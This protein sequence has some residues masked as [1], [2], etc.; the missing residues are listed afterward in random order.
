[1]AT[2]VARGAFPPSLKR[3]GLPH[4]QVFPVIFRPTPDHW[5]EARNLTFIFCWGWAVLGGLGLA[6]RAMSPEANYRINFFWGY[7]VT[8]LGMFGFFWVLWEFENLIAGFLFFV[9]LVSGL[10]YVLQH[11]NPRGIHLKTRFAPFWA[12]IYTL[13]MLTIIP[14]TAAQVFGYLLAFMSIASRRGFYPDANGIYY[15]RQRYR[16]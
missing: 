3:R 6:Y 4:Y 9:A 8:L 14:Y 5:I 16:I 13:A 7:F 12:S 10:Y 15:N 1:M 11:V 2:K